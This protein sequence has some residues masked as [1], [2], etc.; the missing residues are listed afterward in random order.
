MMILRSSCCKV[1]ESGFLAFSPSSKISC[2]VQD[3]SITHKAPYFRKVDSSKCVVC[4]CYDECVCVSD[5]FDFGAA[6][7]ICLASHHHTCNVRIKDPN[8]C[9]GLL[10]ELKKL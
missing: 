6:G 8:L 5:G 1:S 3:R 4:S 10:E 2:I 9:S 7:L